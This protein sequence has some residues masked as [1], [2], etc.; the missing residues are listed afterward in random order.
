LE[1]EESAR[2]VSASIASR[3]LFCEEAR[4]YSRGVPRIITL[5]SANKKFR[6]ALVVQDGE[7][8]LLRQNG[9]SQCEVA[10]LRLVAV[11]ACQ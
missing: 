8:L 11:R 3:A 1:I 6:G 10:A 2:G 9:M 5:L 7:D 4:L